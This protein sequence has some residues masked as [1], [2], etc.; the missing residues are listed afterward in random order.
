M[1]GFTFWCRLAWA[2]AAKFSAASRE[3]KGGSE[4]VAPKSEMS[5]VVLMGA[6]TLER[7][8]FWKNPNVK[9]TVDETRGAVNCVNNSCF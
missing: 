1:K 6:A 8:V 9:L 4:D 3:I 5:I 7:L 2:K